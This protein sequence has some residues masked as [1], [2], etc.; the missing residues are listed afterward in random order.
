MA[1]NKRAL[2]P[3]IAIILILMMTITAAGATFF[4]TTRIQGQQ[5]GGIESIQSRFFTVTTTQAS[6]IRSNFNDST[7]VLNIF[8]QNT[9]NN[10]IP[11][12]NT[13]SYPT[14]EWVVFDSSQ[15]S[16]CS[17]NW[18]ANFPQIN[19]SVKCNR[20]CGTDIPVGQIRQIT[21]NISAAPGAECSL[22]NQPNSTRISF[23]IDFSGKTTASGS[24]DK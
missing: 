20:G 16:I 12:A 21:L 9:G 22:A 2:T 4:F 7:Q 18:G 15:R 6:V 23:T 3:I 24:F 1:L 10:P 11:V 19:T 13:S 8:V 17:S 5:Q 14:T